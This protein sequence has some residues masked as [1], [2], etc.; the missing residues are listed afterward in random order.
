MK[1]G[2][3]VM[4]YQK[5]DSFR[6]FRWKRRSI[7]LPKHT[8]TWGAYFV[9]I[10]AKQHTPLLE[11]PEL[12]TILIETWEALPERFPGVSLD[13]FVIM[14]DHIHFII[15]LDDNVE[16]P[17]TLDKVIQ[18]YKSITTVAWLKHIKLAGL[19][20]PGKFWQRGYFERVIRDSRELELTRQYIQDNP[21]ELCTPECTSQEEEHQSKDQ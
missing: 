18:A 12:H 20:R 1:K 19:E 10:R 17:P 8:Y 5:Y 21:H 9:T 6:S 3:I 13:E 11:I 14:P 7:R 4:S 15:W 16:N 2:G